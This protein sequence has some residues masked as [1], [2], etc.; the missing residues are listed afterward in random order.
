[1][2]T[3]GYV[4]FIHIFAAYEPLHRCF[5]P[6]CDGPNSK[7]NESHTQ[8]S[9]PR[10]GSS[11]NMFTSLN[12]FDPCLMYELNDAIAE[13]VSQMSRSPLTTN[14]MSNLTCSEANFNKVI[15][16]ENIKISLTDVHIKLIHYFKRYFWHEKC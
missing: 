5:I 13:E 6:G 4:L 2:W 14:L 10:E 12:K 1:M 15:F 16:Q 8:F 11:G 3:S 9:I 7:V